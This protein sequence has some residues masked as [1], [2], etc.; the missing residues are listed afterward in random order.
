MARAARSPRLRPTLAALA[1]A[2]LGAPAPAGAAEPPRVARAGEPPPAAPVGTSVRSAPATF[3]APGPIEVSQRWERCIH[4]RKVVVA[5]AATHLWPLG[6]AATAAEAPDRIGARP[7]RYARTPRATPPAGAVAGSANGASAFDGLRDAVSVPGALDARGRRPYTVELWARPAAVDGRGRHLWAQGTREGARAGTG[8]WLSSAGLGFERWSGG[9]RAGITYPAG[10]PAGRWSHVVASYDG[11]LMRLFV[12]GRQV[13]SRATTAPLAATD[14]PLTFGAFDPASGHFHGALDEVAVYDRALPR[15]H[16]AEHER[17]ARAEPC[18]PVPGATGSAYAIRPEDV[19]YSLRVRTTAT[20]ASGSA[21]SVVD[22]ARPVVDAAG[23]PFRVELVRPASGATLT[24][25]VSVEVRVSGLVPERV[26]HLVDGVSRREEAEAPWGHAW[27]TGAEV[28]GRHSLAVRAYRP[29]DASNPSEARLEVVVAN[30]PRGFPAPLPSGPESMY[31]EFNQGDVPTAENLLQDV[32]PARG[33]PLPRLTWPLTWTDDPYG[34]AYWRFFFYALRP[35]ANLL[36]AYETTR[37]RRYLERLQAILRSYVA[38]DATRPFDRLTFDNPHAAAYRAMVLVNTRAKLARWGA[39]P[40]DLDEGLRRSIEKLGGFLENPRYFEDTHNHGFN[41][42]AALLLV[43]HNHPELPAAA[44]WRELG[45]GRLLEMLDNTVDA[46]GVEVEN[47]PFYHVYVLGLVSQIAAWAERYE[48]EVAGPY[49]AAERR[50]LRYAAY[51]TQPDG[52]LPMLGATATTILPNQ[53]PTTYGPLTALSPEFEFVYTRGARGQAPAERSMLFP[54]SGL[55]VLRSPLGSTAELRDQSFVTFDAG[56]YRTDHSHLDALSVTLYSHGAIRVPEA[57]LFTYVPGSDFDY[58][59]G[60]RGHNTVLVDGADQAQGD[61][62]PGRHGT[63]GEAAWASGTSRLY[64]GVEHRRTVVLLRR[65]LVLVWDSLSGSS[66]HRYTQTLAPAPGRGGGRERR[67]GGGP[68][69]RPPV[70]GHRPG[71]GG[72]DRPRRGRGRHGPH[73]GVAL[74]AVRQEG[75]RPRARVRAHGGEH[76]LCHRAG[77]GSLRPLPAHRAQRGGPRGAPAD[78]VRGSEW[79]G[80][81]DPCAGHVARGG[82]GRAAG[83][84]RLGVALPPGPGSGALVARREV[85]V[86][87][88]EPPPPVQAAV[89]VGHPD[90]HGLGVAAVH[91][92]RTA[93]EADGAREVAALVDDDVLGHELAAA[94]AAP[95]PLERP[96]ER[97]RS[98]LDR[99]PGAEQRDV[100]TLVPERRVRGGI[101]A[102]HG[103]DRDLDPSKRPW[104]ALA[105]RPLLEGEGV[106][107]GV[108]EPGDPA[109]A[110]DLGDPALVGS[111]RGVVVALEPDAAAGELVHHALEVVDVPGGQGR[112]RL[113]RVLGRRVHVQRRPACRGVE[114]AAV[115]L[116][117]HRPQAEPILVE[118]PRGA[119]V[120]DGDRRGQPR[121][122]QADAGR[123]GAH[124]PP[125]TGSLPNDPRSAGIA[126]ITPRPAGGRHLRPRATRTPRAAPA[127]GPRG[128]RARSGRPPCRAPRGARSWTR[129]RPRRSRPRSP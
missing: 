62:T 22:G 71:G 49:R 17:V 40:P 7:G 31:P 110:L 33:F 54:V 102:G 99:A 115:G 34:D 32:W 105:G 86:A 45:I 3:T 10:L 69:G 90:R 122:A 1:V 129:G 113:A 127:R 100:G 39:L 116:L 53:D 30:P 23:N 28:N 65:G 12:G 38:H 24:G 35:T 56:A 98:A 75:G 120:G 20:G 21:S 85:G 26:E 91:P 43:A 81:H 72:R 4:V 63:V 42:A 36:W 93:L 80:R 76:E 73:A 6:D 107:V 15:A 57:G 13:G 88:Y 128:L 47:S 103:A 60:T 27:Q 94:E 89:D 14:V 121:R 112:R 55:F 123:V 61:A 11:E 16:V 125:F 58:F 68:R 2:L 37:D 114:P 79:A 78:G 41:E 64:A 118:L 67:T 52:T 101:A 74:V 5:G 104:K 19:G 29:G 87:V 117:L 106:A 18:A 109:A 108:P 83:V 119:H 9:E 97:L 8:V 124:G 66:G 46:D 77:D 84:L 25:R 111:Q 51:V 82:G 95:D 59:H 96:P 48:P 92:D 70:G 44:R 50:M 126:S